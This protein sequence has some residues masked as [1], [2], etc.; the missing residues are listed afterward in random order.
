MD[1]N[2]KGAAQDHQRPSAKPVEPSEKKRISRGAFFSL[3]ASSLAETMGHL[4]GAFFG[5]VLDQMDAVDAATRRESKFVKA[6]PTADLGEDPHLVVVEGGPVYLVH[7]DG[8]YQG[9]DAR[10]PKDGRFLIWDSQS[11]RFSCVACESV[12][13]LEGRMVTE[14]EAPAVGEEGEQPQLR[15]RPLRVEDDFIYV[16]TP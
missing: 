15:F 5:D 11:A 7:R 14:E 6:F 8:C 9:W 12:F 3:M 1:E 2:K 10:C 16:S 4:A 13:D